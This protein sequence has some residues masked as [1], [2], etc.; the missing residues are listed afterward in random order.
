MKEKI[1]AAAVGFGAGMLSGLFGAGG[2]MILVPML[3]K[4]TRL[5]EDQLFPTAVAIL[6]PICVVALIFTRGWDTFSLPQAL[7]YLLGSI[8]GGI[9][10]GLWGRHIPTQ[11]L[12]KV[13]GGLIL[14][15]G[16]RYLW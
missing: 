11:W 10:A 1:S 9:G 2:G 6:F 4:L 13:L 14:W 15:G 8:V 5:Q 7:P 16:V 12:H 3:R